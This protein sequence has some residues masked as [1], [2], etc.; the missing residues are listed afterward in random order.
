[1]IKILR[2]VSRTILIYHFQIHM[3]YHLEILISHNPAVYIYISRH[4]D[5][6]EDLHYIFYHILSTIY[7]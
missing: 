7:H 1:M 3:F 6:D 2:L 5:I 4:G